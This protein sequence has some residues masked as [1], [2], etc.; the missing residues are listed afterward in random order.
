MGASSGDIS[1]Q[2][3]DL[4]FPLGLGAAL[5]AI[6][7]YAALVHEAPAIEAKIAAAAGAA[8]DAAVTAREAA[9]AVDGRDVVVSGY[10]GSYAE[11][12]RTLAWVEEVAGVASVTDAMVELPT[13]EVF[14]FSATR[15]ADGALSA[16]GAAPSV[17]DRA[18]I[19]QRLQALSPEASAEIALALGAPPG[20]WARIVGVGLQGL[21]ALTAG[22]L[23]IEDGALSLAGVAAP[24][25]GAALAAAAAHARAMDLAWRE[26][27]RFDASPAPI[28]GMV[29]EKSPEGLWRIEGVAADAARREYWRGLIRG[30]AGPDVELR[31]GAGAARGPA[32]GPAGWNDAV[33][34]G[35]R[36]LAAAPRGRIAFEWALD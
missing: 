32:E 3:R 23:E 5:F 30:V 12:D 8:A 31:L 20:D 21:S 18:A 17:A 13:L 15:S 34:A 26:D 2:A 7:T 36:A 35:L 9:V 28:F 22:S 33:E 16:L 4:R 1:D 29:I 10:V 25:N 11:R 24:E 14:R 19:T 6:L 27:V